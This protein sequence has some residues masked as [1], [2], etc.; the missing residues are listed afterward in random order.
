MDRKAKKSGVGLCLIMVALLGCGDDKKSETGTGLPQSLK[1]D[2]VTND[3]AKDICDWLMDEGTVFSPTDQQLCTQVAVQSSQ[4]P[5]DCAAFTKTCEPSMAQEPDD[6]ECPLSRSNF[7][8]CQATVK[9]LEACFDAIRTA[10]SDYF[11][12]LSCNDAGLGKEFEVPVECIDLERRCPSIFEETADGGFVCDDGVDLDDSEVCDGFADCTRD[13]DEDPL[14]CAT[15][16]GDDDL[17][18]G[19]GGSG[20]GGVSTSESDGGFV[21]TDG[22]DVWDNTLCDYY[23]D[24]SDG[25]DEVGCTYPMND[26]G[27]VCADGWDLSDW[28]KCDGFTDCNDGSDELECPVFTCN[29]GVIIDLAYQCDGASDCTTGEDEVDCTSTP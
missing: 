6:E 18:G 25:E 8:G 26:G 22:T 3:Q 1:L 2:D 12:K 21:C 19:N 29:D 15:W 24:C 10:A 27:F 9:D 14:L 5:E 7:L 16:E 4:N 13:E 20:S 11:G 23:P 17:T 28:E